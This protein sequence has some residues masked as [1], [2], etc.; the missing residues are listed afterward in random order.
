TKKYTLNTSEI[1][2]IED[3]GFENLLNPPPG[4]QRAYTVLEK[5]LILDS[6]TVRGAMY[7]IGIELWIHIDHKEQVVY[8]THDSVS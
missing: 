1:S 8:I 4:S 2:L 5:E 6:D 7:L 3:G